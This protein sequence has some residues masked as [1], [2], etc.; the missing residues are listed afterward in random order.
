MATP[1]RPVLLDTHALLW[2]KAGSGRLS[3]AA[4]GRI[5]RAPG[6]L[7]SPISVWETAMLVQK[8]R[9]QLDR[10]V[11]AWVDDLLADDRIEPAALTATIAVAA[12]GLDDFH[13]DPADRFLVATARALGIAMVTKDPKIHD[14]AARTE[15]F[16]AVW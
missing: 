4:A 5:G 8:N 10:P 7:I 13:G 1:E 15:G 6:V 12:A 3:D 9:V 2:W 14:Y 11:A 16:D